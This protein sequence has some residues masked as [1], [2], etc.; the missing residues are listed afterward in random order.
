MRKNLFT[1]SAIAI[2]ACLTC[3]EN[4]SSAC[5]NIIVTPGA[6]VDGSAIVSYAADSHVLYGELYFHP[7][8]DWKRGSMLRSGG[9]PRRRMSRTFR[10]PR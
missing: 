3:R 4:S 10:S 8:A 1:L 2:I 6:S 9:G 7:A 5:T